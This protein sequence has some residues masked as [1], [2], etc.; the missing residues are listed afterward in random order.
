M[1]FDNVHVITRYEF[2]IKKK[3]I[4]L[5]KSFLRDIAQSF[6]FM[7]RARENRLP[8]AYNGVDY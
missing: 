7:M 3:Y 2:Y 1:P 6:S 4:F 8:E 5:S